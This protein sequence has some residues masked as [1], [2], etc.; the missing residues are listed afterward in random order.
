MGKVRAV[1]IILA[2]WKVLMG[3]MVGGFITLTKSRVSPWNCILAAPDSVASRHH[4][5]VLGSF[6]LDNFE[7]VSE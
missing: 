3:R 6:F 5:R 4:L 1:L 7:L 2:E